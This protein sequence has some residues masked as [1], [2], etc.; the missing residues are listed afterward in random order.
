[1]FVV[2]FRKSHPIEAKVLEEMKISLDYAIG[3]LNGLE[4]TKL[5]NM[6]LHKGEIIPVQCSEVVRDSFA[7]FLDSVQSVVGQESKE[8]L[9]RYRSIADAYVGRA[10]A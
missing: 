4:T 8:R 6:R 5:V 3:V 9:V 1:L 7:E 2:C 10:Q